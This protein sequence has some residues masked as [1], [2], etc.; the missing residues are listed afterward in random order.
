MPNVIAS[1]IPN[2]TSFGCAVTVLNNFSF[3]DLSICYRTHMKY[4]K[5]NDR[6]SYKILQIVQIL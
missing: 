4:K 1:P 5:T 6:I 3:M 2:V